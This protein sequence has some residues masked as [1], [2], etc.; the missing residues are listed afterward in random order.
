M[1][2][3][4]VQDVVI[5][6]KNEPALITTLGAMVVGFAGLAWQMHNASKDRKLLN[7]KVGDP[8]LGKRQSLDAKLNTIIDGLSRVDAKVEKLI[9]RF[10]SYV[11]EH[12]RRHEDDR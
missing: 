6:T 11:E 12:N 5:T 8:D 3:Q 4:Y 1:F 10:E 2:F 9:G 7:N